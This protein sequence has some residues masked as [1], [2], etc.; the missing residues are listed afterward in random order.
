MDCALFASLQLPQLGVL[1]L[2]QPA[3][4]AQVRPAL[5]HPT[6]PGASVVVRQWLFSQ[7]LAHDCSGTQ[8]P[9][10]HCSRPC[11]PQ[12]L[13]GAWHSLH[14]PTLQY[15]AAFAQALSLIQDPL[16]HTSGVLPAAQ[17]ADCASEQAHVP[18]LLTQTGVSSAHAVSLTHWW[19]LSQC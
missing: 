17:R 5:P 4:V 12:R 13:L 15:G 8:S 2:Q 18:V 10:W 14:L 1:A 7:P 3:P 6:T 16:L 9:F 19:L 11:A